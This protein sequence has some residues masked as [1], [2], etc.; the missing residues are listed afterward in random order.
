MRLPGAGDH[1]IAVEPRL[2]GVLLFGP[3]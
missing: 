3:P 2:V 1:W